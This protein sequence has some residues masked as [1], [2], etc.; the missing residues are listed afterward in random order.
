MKI[1]YGPFGRA[2]LLGVFLGT[3][4]SCPDALAS[5]PI[6]YAK[7][8]VL[9]LSNASGA[10]SVPTGVEKVTILG[11]ASVVPASVVT[12]LGAKYDGRLSGSNRYATAK[13]VAEYGV[14]QGMSWNNVGV[15]TGQN[16]P[17]A[18]CAGPLVG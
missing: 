2:G 16:F 15:A 1:R 7:G 3:G 4:V 12:A 6:M 5:S 13:A 9:I 10:F 11:D 17:D 18:L 14:S 8:M